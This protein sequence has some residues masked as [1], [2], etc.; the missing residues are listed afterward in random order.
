MAW[1]GLQDCFRGA[2]L[3]AAI[4]DALGAPFEGA[5]TV[6]LDKLERLLERPGPLRYTDDTHMTLGMAESL[7]AC[8]GFDGPHMAETFARNFEAEPWRGYGAGPPQV[9]RLIRQGVEWDQAGRALFNGA[10]SFG[11]GAAMRVAPAALAYFYDTEEVVRVARQ[12]AL[13]THAHELGVE[14]AVLQALAVAFLVQMSTSTP[15]DSSAFVDFLLTRISSPALVYRL[16]YIKTMR[17]GMTRE[18]DVQALGNGIA[19]YEAVPAAICAFLHHPNSFS[20]AVTYAISLGGDTDTIA[21]MTG[22]LAGARLG[23]GAIPHQWR[24]GIEG[25][26][27][28]VELADALLAL[29]AAQRR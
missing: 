26:V 13:I 29:V 22:A 14:G 10:G 3:G 19:A 6:S 15:L 5:P 24:E 8:G 23:A 21:S 27:R 16:I 25:S 12:S 11:N 18:E 9:F 28:L 1:G 4:G 20:Q 17:P 7:V 2:L